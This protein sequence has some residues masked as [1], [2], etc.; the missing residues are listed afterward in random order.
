[1]G[2]WLMAGV[3]AYGAMLGGLFV[4]QRNLLYFPA[5]EVGAP[6]DHDVP[7]MAVVRYATA[8]GLTLTGWYR[9][10]ADGRPTLAYFHGNGGHFGERAFKVRRYLDAGCGVL[11]A[12]YR[13]YGGNPGRPSEQGLYADARAAL[14]WL[15][16]QG[17]PAGHVVLYGESLGSGVAVQMATEQ[18]VAGL[19][20]EAAFTSITAIGARRY[21][22][23]PVHLLLRDRYD[24]LAKIGRITA[25]VLVV[26]GD[27][28][29]T[30]P[31]SHGRRLFESAPNRREAHF[32]TGGGHADLADFGIADRVLAF[33]ESVGLRQDG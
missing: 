6:A 20:L 15:A 13:G 17:V 16:G 19:V 9:P 31:V 32:V 27:R 2:A 4:F 5:G 33:L 25:P 29:E 26:H 28:D 14:A 12:E 11:L 8:D 30:V 7:E 23:V 21:P 3:A 1:M 10:A 24:N 22:F 18:P